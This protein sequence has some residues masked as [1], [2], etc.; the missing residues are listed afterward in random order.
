VQ[1]CRYEIG[2]YSLLLEQSSFFFFK[3]HKYIRIPLFSL[4]LFH[5]KCINIPQECHSN[6]TLFN[7]KC[8]QQTIQVRQRV[9]HKRTFFYLEQLLLKHSAH[10]KALSIQSFRDGMDFFFTRR[11]E[12]RVLLLVLSSSGVL[13]S[14]KENRVSSRGS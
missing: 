4:N 8:Q 5:C 6:L 10:T 3:I 2:D 11:N 7:K 14:E 1:W 9:D 13:V 12:V